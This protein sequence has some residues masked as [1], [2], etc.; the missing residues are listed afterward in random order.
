MLLYVVVCCF[1]LLNVITGKDTGGGVV[2]E[3]ANIRHQIN[4]AT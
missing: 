2:E 1:M 3:T 4:V